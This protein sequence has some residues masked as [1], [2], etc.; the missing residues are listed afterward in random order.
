MK[1]IL[2]EEMMICEDGVMR[3]GED[4]VQLLEDYYDKEMEIESARLQR[5]KELWTPK[6]AKVTFIEG[7]PSKVHK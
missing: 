3:T 2:V 4:V 7:S 1:E 5:E 6:P